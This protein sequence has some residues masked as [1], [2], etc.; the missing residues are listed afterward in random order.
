MCHGDLSLDLIRC[1]VDR[2]SLLLCSIKGILPSSPTLFLCQLSRLQGLVR[3]GGVPRQP[4]S[5]RS[6][7]P[8]GGKAATCQ[9]AQQPG[10]CRHHRAC[11]CIASGLPGNPACHSTERIRQGHPADLRPAAE[12]RANSTPYQGH[13]DGA[14]ERRNRICPVAF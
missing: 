1:G 3:C 11:P 8:S 5:S 7:L 2:L 12:G 4:A 9:P 10:S 14:G 13:R 6:N